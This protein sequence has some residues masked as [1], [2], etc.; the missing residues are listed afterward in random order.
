MLSVLAL[1]VGRRLNKRNSK[2]MAAKQQINWKMQALDQFTWGHFLSSLEHVHT[3]ILCLPPSHLLSNQIK[4]WVWMAN[5]Y[6][7][8]CGTLNAVDKKPTREKHVTAASTNFGPWRQDIVTRWPRAVST[9]SFLEGLKMEQRSQVFQK[10]SSLATI[11]CALGPPHTKAE[12]TSPS[13]EF[14]DGSCR[15]N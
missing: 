9:V 15:I 14:L 8:F 3:Y 12:K 13:L 5:F 4:L 11:T 7:Q 10:H 2:R 1:T 6:V